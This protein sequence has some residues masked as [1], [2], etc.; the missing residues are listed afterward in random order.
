MGKGS[1]GGEED[2]ES[3]A[4]VLFIMLVLPF[5]F[6]Q[7]SRDWHLKR[8]AGASNC[9]LSLGNFSKEWQSWTAGSRVFVRN[10]SVCAV[11][12]ECDEGKITGTYCSAELTE[13]SRLD[14]PPP[15]ALMPLLRLLPGCE[16]SGREDGDIEF[17]KVMRRL[18]LRIFTCLGAAVSLLRVFLCYFARLSDDPFPFSKNY[19]VGLFSACET[20]NRSS[21]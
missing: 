7:N 10:M 2:L 21:N 11:L 17:K 6:E 19:L 12:Q 4:D 9:R 3:G 20:R 1:D 5:P 13:N 14:T 8:P 16:R 15:L 18:L